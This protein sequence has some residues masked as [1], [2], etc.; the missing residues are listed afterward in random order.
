MYFTSQFKDFSLPISVSRLFQGLWI[1]I[2]GLHFTPRIPENQVN[3]ANSYFNLFHKGLS[4]SLKG[5]KMSILR[6]KMIWTKKW[7][8]RRRETTSHPFG[9]LTHNQPGCIWHFYIVSRKMF[10]VRYFQS[11]S[12]RKLEQHP[13]RCGFPLS[14]YS[15]CCENGEGSA[16][17][18]N[19]VNRGKS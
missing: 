2:L 19:L 7:V 1:I 16:S 18:Q 6:P 8:A 11:L 5:L 4:D 3:C 13:C 12:G 14:P 10:S 17:A 9:A 15:T